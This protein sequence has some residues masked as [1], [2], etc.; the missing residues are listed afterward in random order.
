MSLEIS[1]ENK[2]LI[3]TLTWYHVKEYVILLFEVYNSTEKNISITNNNILLNVV[4]NSSE[5][6]MEFELYNEINSTESNYVIDD[7]SIR[8][9]LKKA[10][11]DNWS[12]LTKDKNL[13]KNNIKINWNRWVNDSDDENEQEQEQQNPF[14]GNQQFDFQQMMQSM[15]GMGGMGGMEG[16]GDMESMMKAMGDMG[17]YENNGEGE[18]GEEGEEEDDEDHQYDDL[19]D[20]IPINDEEYNDVPDLVDNNDEDS[21]IE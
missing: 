5:Y 3:P 10:N 16:M 6:K 8:M 13:Y 11:D 4:S 7:K 19:P 2:V 14:G 1:E 20:L 18:E 21:S 12:S 9:I 15:G 17:A